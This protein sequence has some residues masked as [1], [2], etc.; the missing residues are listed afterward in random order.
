MTGL[1]TAST[2]SWM[3]SIMHGE[4]L[5]MHEPRTVMIVFWP[6][7]TTFKPRFSSCFLIHLMPCSCGSIMSGQRAQLVTMAPFSVDTGSAGSCSLFQPATCE[8]V[9]STESGFMPFSDMGTPPLAEATSPF[10]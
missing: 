1:S 3:F 8:G 9:V 5:S 4:P 6:R 7:R 10:R 2:T